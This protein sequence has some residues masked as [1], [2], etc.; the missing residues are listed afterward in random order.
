MMKSHVLYRG[1]K[2]TSEVNKTNNQ[3]EA[4]IFSEHLSERGISNTTIYTYECCNSCKYHAATR[5]HYVLCQTNSDT[6]EVHDRE[7]PY[8]ML[9][10]NCPEAQHELTR[11]VLTPNCTKLT[12]NGLYKLPQII[13]GLSK[14]RV[15]V[16]CEHLEDTFPDHRTVYITSKN[17]NHRIITKVHRAPVQV[18]P[19]EWLNESY[20][21]PIGAWL[22]IP[23]IVGPIADNSYNLLFEQ[24]DRRLLEKRFQIHG[25]I[26]A[27]CDIKKTER[28]DEIANNYLDTYFK[29]SP[30]NRELKEF[31][32]NYVD[33]IDLRRYA[34]GDPCGDIYDAVIRYKGD[35]RTFLDAFLENKTKIWSPSYGIMTV[36][37]RRHNENLEFSRDPYVLCTDTLSFFSIRMGWAFKYRGITWHFDLVDLTFNLIDPHNCCSYTQLV[38]MNIPNAQEP[39]YTYLRGRYITEEEK[40]APALPYVIGYLSNIKNKL[41]FDKNDDNDAKLIKSIHRFLDSHRDYASLDIDE[42]K[43]IEHQPPFTI[44]V[45]PKFDRIV[46]NLNPK[47]SMVSKLICVRNSREFRFNTHCP[48]CYEDEYLV[49]VER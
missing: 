34:N 49:I 10:S 39:G 33:N 31:W 30:M 44:L 18:E 23:Y 1:R 3:C 32:D 45:H 46:N 36:S 29:Y 19:G 7:A 28:I 40:T 15:D 17:Q 14:E 37:P 22:N 35:A 12:V 41:I 9:H 24:D 2:I 47:Y 25:N 5:N 4:A 42:T 16:R 13:F 8:L 38:E 21:K 11:K 43:P 27:H 20:V 48:I 26:V 6:M